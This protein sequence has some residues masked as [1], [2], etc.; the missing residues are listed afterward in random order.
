MCVSRRPFGSRSLKLRQP[1]QQQQLLSLQLLS[2]LSLLSLAGVQLLQVLCGSRQDR[3]LRRLGAVR[4]ARDLVPKRQKAR[5]QVVPA[6]A[7]EE[8]VRLAFVC[9]LAV[10]RL[11]AGQVG[12]GVGLHGG[13]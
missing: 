10:R 1:L 11:G 6:L 3:H 12:Q 13:A 7:F 8:V 2:L 9:V 4:Q 5:A